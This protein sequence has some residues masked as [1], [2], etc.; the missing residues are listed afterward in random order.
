MNTLARAKGKGKFPVGSRVFSKKVGE[1]E[2]FEGVVTE[3]FGSSYHVADKNGKGW[4]RE[5]NELHLI[6]AGDAQ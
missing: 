4:L 5:S 1:R 6:K 3:H 2:A